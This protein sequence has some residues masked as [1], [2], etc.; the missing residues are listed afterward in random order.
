MR[1]PAGFDQSLITLDQR[2]TLVE[3]G[4]MGLVQADGTPLPALDVNASLAQP[5]GRGGAAYLVYEN[6]RTILRWNRSQFF[7]TAVGHLADRLGS[8]S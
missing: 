1:L 3:W 8:G 2:R 6:Y 7:A 5:A 4:R